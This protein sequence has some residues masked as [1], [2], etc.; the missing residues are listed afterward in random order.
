MEREARRDEQ[1]TSGLGKLAVTLR[2]QSRP[3]L[4]PGQLQFAVFWYRV[5][6]QLVQRSSKDS[7]IVVIIK[8][9]KKYCMASDVVIHTEIMFFIMKLILLMT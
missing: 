7:L 9:W 4:L 2:P 5:R 8:G 6:I 1:N 3:R